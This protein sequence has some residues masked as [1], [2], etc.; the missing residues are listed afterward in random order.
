LEILDFFGLSDQSGQLAGILA[1]GDQR[2]L[3][4]ARALATDPKLI[5]LDEPAAGMNPQESESLKQTI[6]R[7]R[8]ELGMTV[9]LVE[10]D[11]QFVMSLCERIQVLVHGV[12]LTE[13]Q[14]QQIQS[15]PE[16]IEAYLGTPR[17]SPKG[18]SNHE[19]EAANQREGA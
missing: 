16:V 3:E 8:N 1:Y 19:P 7:L 15:D 5:L 17:K 4:M 6:G 2:R 11:M 18:R 14:P 12:L 9:L 10:H 13:G